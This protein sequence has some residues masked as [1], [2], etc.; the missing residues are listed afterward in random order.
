MISFIKRGWGV[1]LVLFV[2]IA[3]IATGILLQSNGKIETTSLRAGDLVRVVK[4]SGKVK[5]EE[6][7][8]LGFEISG[9]VSNIVKDVGDGVI[10]GDMIAKLDTSTI[11][12]D[13]LKAEAELSLAE[14]NLDKLEAP[15]PLRHR[16]RTPSAL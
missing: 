2:I 13:I 4:I 11:L 14:A 10:R 3:V 9:T 8:E 15:E 7:V 12:S 6:S 5:P 1:I 16:L